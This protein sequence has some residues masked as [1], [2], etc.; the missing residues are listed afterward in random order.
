MDKKNIRKPLLDPVVLS[1]D[2]PTSCFPFYFKLQEVVS[3]S[4]PLPLT[5]VPCFWRP[6]PPKTDLTKSTPT[7]GVKAMMFCSSG[8]G[9]IPFWGTKILHAAQCG[10][11]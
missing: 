1:T 3:L 6:H 11:K 5:L 8:T 2:H 7:T 9:S 10:Q 4:P